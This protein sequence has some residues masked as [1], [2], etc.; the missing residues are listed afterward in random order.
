M[1]RILILFFI[2]CTF[3]IS[4][5]SNELLENFHFEITPEFGI[6]NGSIEEYVFYKNCKNTDNKLSELDWDIKNIFYFGANVEVDLFKY[7]YLDFSFTYAFPKS[8]GKMQD[9][10]WLNSVTS[11]WEEDP[12]TELT[13]YSCHDNKVDNLYT[14]N[15]YA[16]GNIY[17]PKEIILTPYLGYEYDFIYFFGENGYGEYKD[18]PYVSYEG[19][20]VISYKQEINSFVLGI[21]VRTTVIPFMK[22]SGIVQISP[23]TSNIQALDCHL[24][25]STAFLDSMSSS[26]QLKTKLYA[27]YSINMHHHLGLTG[28]LQWIPIT[29]GITNSKRLDY[30]GNPVSGNWTKQPSLGGTSRFIW[31][32]G[33]NYNYTF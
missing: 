18:D 5:I 2:Y 19:E 25:R 14:F 13:S 29:K 7:L 8:S 6:L 28:S 24:T 31:G 17:L 21:K 16:G 30:Y 23:C 12:P 10:D 20:R 32:I 1:K 27:D 15:V 33:I 9:Y 11:G 4:A 26:F 3:S 22:L